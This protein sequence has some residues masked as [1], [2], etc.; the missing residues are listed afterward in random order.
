MAPSVIVETMEDLQALVREGFTDWRSLGEISVDHRDDLLLFN[1][2]SK[3]VYANTW[4]FVECVARGLILDASGAVVAR[5]FE[6]FFNFGENGRFPTAPL[7]Y[8]MD[9]ID[10]SLGV[11]YRA[12]DDWRV[13]TRGRLDSPQGRWA[14]AWMEQ[15]A[16]L[17]F[18]G[19][20]WT[21]LVEIVYPGNRVVVDYGDQEQCLLLALRNRF[22]GDYADIK[23][24][25]AVGDDC[26]LPLAP[27]QA[28]SS[29]FTVLELLPSLPV[30]REGF[31]AVYQDQARFKLKGEAYLRLHKAISRLTYKNTVALVQ[32]GQVDELRPV[33]PLP[34]L[35]RLET[36][37]AE[38]QD[39]SDQIVAMVESIYA[40]APKS[41]RKEYAEYVKRN[42]R[43]YLC[44]QVRRL[45]PYLFLR[46]DQRDY[47]ESL[48]TR[49]FAVRAAEVDGKTWESE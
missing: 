18:A 23:A 19:D 25:Y 38:I 7:D 32:M 26:G 17:R 6:K 33:L 28:V 40:A 29:I 45:E 15:H 10:G 47:R 42:G 48:F 34:H 43:A 24:L 8:V 2:T 39:V 46:Y 49:E 31:V 44:G 21:P 5:P 22:T 37:I 11:C 12:G 41:D 9:K 3:A 16:A 20:A 4:N 27:V 35:N 1:Y 13:S 30:T 14:T 36:W